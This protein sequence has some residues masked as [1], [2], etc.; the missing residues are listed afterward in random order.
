MT[1]ARISS[2]SNSTIFLPFHIFHL[3]M[4]GQ[5][6]RLSNNS[7]VCTCWCGTN[8]PGESS[9]TKRF[10]LSLFFCRC[11]VLFVSLHLTY[12]FI[13]FA[14]L[15]L[16]KFGVVHM[17]LYSWLNW[18]LR[19]FEHKATMAYCKV[20]MHDLTGAPYLAMKLW[21][22][23]VIASLDTDCALHCQHDALQDLGPH[24]GQ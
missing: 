6:V 13:Y 18:L 2:E 17:H 20:Q 5:L 21:K 3:I 7:V 14:D 23:D 11:T 10:V 15:Q 9:S 22:S 8:N 24:H 16:C 19:S 12:D 1:H 4:H